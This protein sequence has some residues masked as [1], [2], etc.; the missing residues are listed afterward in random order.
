MKN[1]PNVFFFLL[2]FF[3][4]SYIIQGKASGI[5]AKS[6]LANRGAKKYRKN[7]KNKIKKE[8]EVT[9]IIP[10]IKV[11]QH[12]Y[13][14]MNTEIKNKATFSQRI[15]R[16]AQDFFSPTKTKFLNQKTSM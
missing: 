16:N 9:Y 2:I 7:R 13:K 3:F 11:C 6:N 12:E 14:L 4:F 5:T 15:H 8:Q 10:S 1:K